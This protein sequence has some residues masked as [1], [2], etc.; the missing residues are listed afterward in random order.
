M[1]S[2]WSYWKL[3]FKQIRGLHEKMERITIHSLTMRVLFRLLSR[4]FQGRNQATDFFLAAVL[5]LADD[6]IFDDVFL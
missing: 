6:F 4:F 3:F 2:R 5:F 1:L